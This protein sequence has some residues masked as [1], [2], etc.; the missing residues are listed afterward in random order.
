MGKCYFR[1]DILFPKK[2]SCYWPLSEKGYWVRVGP[3]VSLKKD[4]GMN[5][6]DNVMVKVEKWAH[7][8]QQGEVQGPAPGLRQPPVSM[9]DRG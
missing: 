4:L 8:I 7:E 1:L 2:D 3:P 6:G 5:T 9:Q